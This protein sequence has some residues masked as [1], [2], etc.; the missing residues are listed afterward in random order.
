MTATRE[1][2]FAWV[3]VIVAAV[4][5]VALSG[6]VIIQQ[7][8]DN[9]NASQQAAANAAA[10]A[11]QAACTDK[12]TEQTI[13]AP[14]P[15]IPTGTVSGLQTTDLT[16]GTG[17][18]AKAGDCLVVKYYGTLAANGQ[19]FDDNFSNTSGLAFLV[20]QGQVIQGWDQ[21][22]IGTKVGGTRRLV[23]PAA[24]AYGSQSPSPSI[25]ANSDLVFVVKLLRI[26]K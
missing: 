19:R 21:G 3:G 12:Q 1:R 5:A 18:A 26:Q 4:S 8:I 25:P 11:A 16:P 23:I 24:L 15:Y 22:L 6:A 9:K 17:A 14:T 13:P 7:V 20:G 10:T 2:V